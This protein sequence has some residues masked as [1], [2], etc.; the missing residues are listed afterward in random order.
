MLVCPG[1]SGVLGTFHTGI[2]FAGFL[3]MTDALAS[4]A[5]HGEAGT[6]SLVD[7]R[8]ELAC[9]RAE[10]MAM[11]AEMAAIKKDLLMVRQGVGILLVR[12]P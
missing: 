12:R 11:R 1:A 9:M 5:A 2:R 3:W 8:A 7:L 4:S 6:D 10:M